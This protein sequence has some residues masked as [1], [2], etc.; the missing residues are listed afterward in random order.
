MECQYCKSRCAKNGRQKTGA[1]KYRCMN[2]KK[3]QQKKYK[4]QACVQA[5]KKLIVPLILHNCGFR[6][7]SEVLRL[8]VNTVR[9]TILSEAEKC[10]PPRVFRGG[11]YQVDEM[12]AYKK[13]GKPEI[14]ACYAIEKKS[15]KVLVEERN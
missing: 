13:I 7:T 15:K 10:K 4:N 8:S 6:A 1:Q 12:C 3:Y 11:I 9:S 2:C 5:T 14:W